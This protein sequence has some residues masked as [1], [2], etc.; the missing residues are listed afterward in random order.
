MGNKYEKKKEKKNNPPRWGAVARPPPPGPA[1]GGAGGIENLSQTDEYQNQRPIGPQHVP[2]VEPGPVIGVEKQRPD[3]DQNDRKD[4][5]WALMANVFWHVIGHRGP[6]H[7]F[8]R[9]DL[10]NVSLISGC[11]LN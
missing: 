6:L 9:R 1:P 5:R 2:D 7:L 10:A 4:Q 11:R 3:D 8:I